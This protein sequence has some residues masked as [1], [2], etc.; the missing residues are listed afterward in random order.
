MR[1]RCA[2][3]LVALAGLGAALPVL[4]EDWLPSRNDGAAKQAVI[5]FVQVTTDPARSD[6][7]AGCSRGLTAPA[8]RSP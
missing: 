8:Q 5:K 7:S 3:L 2:A 4:A 6:R 1:T